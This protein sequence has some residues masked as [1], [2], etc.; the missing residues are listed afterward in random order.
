M[1]CGPQM[2]RRIYAAV[3]GHTD[4]QFLQADCVATCRSRFRYNRRTA[5]LRRVSTVMHNR[6]AGEATSI[7]NR[8]LQNEHRL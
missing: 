5:S 7:I 6:H 1:E 4:G 3:A 2:L 8:L